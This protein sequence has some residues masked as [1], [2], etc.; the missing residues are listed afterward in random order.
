MTTQELI[1][2]HIEEKCKECTNVC[3]GIHIT[4]EGKT[5]CDRDED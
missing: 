1:K 5:K 2:K 3:D 4:V